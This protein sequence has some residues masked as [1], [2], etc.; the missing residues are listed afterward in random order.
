MVRCIWMLVAGPQICFAA[1][2]DDRDIRT[3]ELADFFNPLHADELGMI[4][5]EGAC[6]TLVVT[7]SS[8]S[9]VSSANAMRMTWDW[10]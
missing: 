7:F 10:A 8:E 6:R 9:G 1:D 3:A 5:D 2:K 4:K